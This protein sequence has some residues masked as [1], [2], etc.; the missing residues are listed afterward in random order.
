MSNQLDPNS[1]T[2][3]PKLGVAEAITL[4]RILMQ[5][6][7]KASSPPVRKAAALVEAARLDLET[8]WRQH[9]GPVQRTEQRALSRR[10]GAAWKGVRD[11]LVAFELLPEDNP[12]RKRSAIILE[13]IFF[14]GLEF[15]LGTLAS[16]HAES[17]R[18]LQL[19]EEQGLEKDLSRLVG[20]DFVEALEEVHERFGDAIG[21]TKRVNRRVVVALTEPLRKLADAITVY[22]VQL[23]GLA[24]HDPDK[25]QAVADALS[26]IDEFRAAANRRVTSGDD[27]VEEEDDQSDVEVDD[28][29]AEPVVAPPVVTPPPVIALAPVA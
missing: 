19:V 26:P 29:V 2:R 12:D 10:L 4:A 21:A 13:T 25:Q 5:L 7:P 24:Y 3:F 8:K 11:R 20:A 1:Y 22:A 9:G 17:D 16:Q 23:L 6:T 28:I 14:G 18:R 27:E 15:S